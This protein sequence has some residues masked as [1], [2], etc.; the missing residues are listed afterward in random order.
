MTEI[1]FITGAAKRV[2]ADIARRL[3]NTGA[4]VVL[5]YR[6]SAEEAKALRDELNQV[7]DNS[8]ACMQADLADT[9]RL[10]SMVQ[11]A[12][13]VWGKLDV[14][15]NNA[16]LFYPTPVDLTTEAH[17]HELIDSNLK[18]PF[19]LCQAAQPF[20]R[21][22]LGCI[23]NIIDIHAERPLKGYSVYSI[24]KAGLAALTR[25]LAKEF[26]PD[27]RVNGVAPGAIM[28]PESDVSDAYHQTK[29]LDR[30][31]LNRKGAPDD[32]A[33]AVLYF[34]RDAQYVTGQILAVD[35]GR[36]LFS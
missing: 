23:V 28:W 30:I 27:I 16:S 9:S 6:T 35:G 24:T 8:A 13:E 18:A 21:K 17:W 31:A 2:G 36:T 20:L 22:Q 3:H 25:S 33:K 10:P 4:N 34:I 7:R 32:I 12:S 11:E 14:L 1:A 5:H 26:A 29:I 15:I 19:F